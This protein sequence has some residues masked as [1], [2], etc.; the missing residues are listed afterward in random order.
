VDSLTTRGDSV[1]VL[2]YF[3]TG[4]RANLE[5]A[6]SSNLVERGG[7]EHPD[8]GTAG[9]PVLVIGALRLGTPVLDTLLAVVSRTR[10][11]VSMVTAGRD[12]LT[13]GFT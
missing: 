11:G 1:L 2:D 12:H 10:R 5:H 3:S 8:G 13:H 4:S 7:D 9:W 6:L